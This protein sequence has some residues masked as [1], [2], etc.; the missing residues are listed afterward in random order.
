MYLLGKI[1]AT[2]WREL[3]PKP[4]NKCLARAVGGKTVKWARLFSGALWMSSVTVND[5]NDN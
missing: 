4:P 3:S 5:F 2:F 1:S